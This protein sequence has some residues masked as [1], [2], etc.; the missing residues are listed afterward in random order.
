MFVPPVDSGSALGGACV[1]R[2]RRTLSRQMYLWIAFRDRKARR[3]YDELLGSRIPPWARSYSQT[4][5]A[6]QPAAAV[7]SN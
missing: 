2:L 3:L 5:L 7:G 1:G 6:P 4:R